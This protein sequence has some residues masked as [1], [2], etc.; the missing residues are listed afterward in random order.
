V[1]KI[2]RDVG[3]EPLLGWWRDT[4]TLTPTSHTLV[5]AIDSGSGTMKPVITTTA[6]RTSAPAAQSGGVTESGTLS[7]ELRRELSCNFTTSA[8]P[9]QLTLLRDFQDRLASCVSRLVQF[10]G[11]SGVRQR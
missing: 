2:D 6:T 7:S 10:V 8:C 5:A 11:A 4:F 9:R 3:R 1:D